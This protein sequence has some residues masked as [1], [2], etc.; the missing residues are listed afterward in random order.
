MTTTGSRAL[1]FEVEDEGA[2]QRVDAALAELAGVSRSQ[3]RRWIDEGR[4]RIDGE[5]VRPSRRLDVGD[6]IEA[7]PPEPVA[8]ELLPE[9]IALVVLYEDASLVVVDKPAGLVV[10]PAP[11]H[12]SGTLVNALL[13]H[14]GDLAGIGGVLRPGIV[15]RLDRG[16]SGVMVV[17]KDDAAHQHL[18]R[19]FAEHSIERVY[20]TFVRGLPGADSGRID[21]PIG[22]HPRDRKR[23]SVET[24]AGRPSITR[25]HVVR[26]FPAAGTSE[27]EIRPETGRTHQIRVHLS[28]A[29]LPIV[30]D[31]VYGRARGAEARLGRPA[32]HA[33]R[34]GFVHP[35]S[36]AWLSFEAPL[37]EDLVRLVEG[38]G[39]GEPVS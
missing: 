3:V 24:R 26:R 20:R 8:T 35:V 15:H 31:V 11:G 32:L 39:P 10:H 17:A 36:G 38:F 29:G 2:G 22:R 6:T 13:H 9:A 1:V 27:L 33:E 12:P 37:P 21:R 18:S 25:W 19:Q 14:C 28:S 34:L 30:G 23:M 5:P 16:T 4:V 7:D